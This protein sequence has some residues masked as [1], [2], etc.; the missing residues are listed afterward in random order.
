MFIGLYSIV[1][2]QCFHF[3][4]TMTSYII[5][6]CVFMFVCVRVS[7]KCNQSIFRIHHFVTVVCWR[8]VTMSCLYLSLIIF[9]VKNTI[10]SGFPSFSLSLFIGFESQLNNNKLIYAIHSTDAEVKNKLRR[11]NADG[12]QN[13]SVNEEKRRQI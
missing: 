7:E 10:N 4:A 3:M 5:N 2:W 9:Y 13:D 11:K 12:D 6:M 8:I 1:Q